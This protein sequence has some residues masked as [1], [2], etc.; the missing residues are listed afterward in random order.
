MTCYQH[1]AHRRSR[2]LKPHAQ[3]CMNCW[4]ARNATVKGAPPVR[5][6]WHDR[7]TTQFAEA[8]TVREGVGVRESSRRVTAR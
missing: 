6:A 3:L 2:M 5:A 8:V 4:R 1:R 7:P